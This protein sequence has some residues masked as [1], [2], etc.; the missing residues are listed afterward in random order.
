ME[1][2]IKKTLGEIKKQKIK[3]A[4]RWQYLLRKY[5]LWLGFGAMIFLGAI[6]F[7]VAFE[8]LNQLDWDLYRFAH[9]SAILYSLSLLPYFWLIF[10]GI[11]LVLAFFDLRKTETGYKYGW[12]KMSVFSIGGIILLGWFFSLVG[13]GG[14][15]NTILAKDLP[16]Y[17]QHLIMTKEKQW[18]Q[19]AAGFLAGKIETASA[20]KLEISDLNGQ[21]WS[22]LLDEKTLTKPAVRFLIGER[23][24]IIGSRKEVNVFQALEIRPWS[25]QGMGN[26]SGGGHGM[27]NGTGA[28]AALAK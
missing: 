20:D 11:F 22:V 26:G 6:S 14:K 23:L 16:Y 5:A 1:N 15:L 19:P 10:I 21:K 12:L 3:P 9:Q 18:M 28:G 27:G 8:M 13:L 2:L 24:K 7:S 17:G 4:P 25:G